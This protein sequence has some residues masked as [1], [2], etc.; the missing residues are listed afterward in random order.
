MFLPE[1]SP[2]EVIMPDI[3]L[4]FVYLWS[5]A[6]VLHVYVEAEDIFQ[7]LALSYYIA[8]SGN[9]FVLRL[10]SEHPYPRTPHWPVLLDSLQ[11]ESSS[12]LFAFPNNALN[13]PLNYRT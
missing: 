13:F 8:H 12:N 7:E 2:Q 1:M 9:G 3:F 4:Y 6:R 10:D 5:G 11:N